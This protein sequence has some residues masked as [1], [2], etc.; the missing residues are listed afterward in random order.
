MSKF[1]PYDHLSIVLD[2][3]GTLTRNYNA[4]TVNANPD[5][6][7]DDSTVSKD[8]T[9]NVEKKTWLRIYCRL[10]CHPMTTLWPGFRS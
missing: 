3:D 6:S 1:D 2:S 8:I 10:N 4:P 7:P 9:L 5:P